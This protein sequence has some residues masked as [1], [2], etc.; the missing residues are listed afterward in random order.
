M[1]KVIVLILCC[2]IAFV[3]TGCGRPTAKGALGK[4]LKDVRSGSFLEDSDAARDAVG[5]IELTDDDVADLLLSKLSYEILSVKEDGDKATAEVKIS[6]VDM[7]AVL[8]KALTGYLAEALD[9]ATSE[10]GKDMTDKEYSQMF[11][12]HISKEIEKE[13]VQMVS[14]TVKVD[15]SYIGDQWEIEPSNDFYDAILGGLLTGEFV[16]DTLTGEDIPSLA[17]EAALTQEKEGDVG[18]YHIVLNDAKV[19]KDYDEMAVIISYTWTNNGDETTSPNA[20]VD[21]NVFQNGISMEPAFVYSENYDDEAALKSVRPGATIKA[22]T[23]FYIEDMSDI[24]V[25]VTESWGFEDTGTVYRTFSLKKWEV[26]MVNSFLEMQIKNMI[27]TV[28]GFE[29][30]CQ[31]AAMQ[32]DGLISKAEEKALRKV[33]AAAAAFMSELQKL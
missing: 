2:S 32:D 19:I 3:L 29:Q 27:V 5:E 20:S 30:A 16:E 17:K 25:E 24:D 15:M 31:I 33:R 8:E 18:D 7:D 14:S 26:H 12:A 1:K 28:Q 23:A 22:Q 11:L 9:K 21:V 6:N 13:D 4:Y 10:N